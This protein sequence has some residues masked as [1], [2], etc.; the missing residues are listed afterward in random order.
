MF[1]VGCAVW[2]DSIFFVALTKEQKQKIVKKIKENLD[3][4][5]M[6]LFVGIAGLKAKDMLDLRKKLKEKV[7]LM[8]VV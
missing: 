1:S 7:C 4:Q 8:N 2:G 3:K 6:L 5:K